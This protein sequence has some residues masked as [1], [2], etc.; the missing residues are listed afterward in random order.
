M[1]LRKLRVIHTPT[2]DWERTRVFYREVLGL[3]E[4]G[5][6][7]RPGDRGAFLTGGPGELELMEV[8]AVSLGVLP[9]S[10]GW[11]LALQVDDIAAEHARLC[12]HPGVVMT[13]IRSQPWG[14]RDFVVVDPEGNPVLLYEQ[15]EHAE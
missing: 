3:D 7:E 5:S 11:Q 9:E 6:W 2:R 15:P 13:G 14:S 10:G 12:E 4:T 1:A 8:D